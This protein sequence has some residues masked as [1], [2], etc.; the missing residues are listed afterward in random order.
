M[1]KDEVT[2]AK[3]QM[4]REVGNSVLLRDLIIDPVHNTRML[5]EGELQKIADPGIVDGHVNSLLL[6]LQ[7]TELALA[8]FD[9]A[10]RITN[11]PITFGVVK[12]RIDRTGGQSTNPKV[13]GLHD[14]VARRR[15]EISEIG[16]ID[17]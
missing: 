4:H 9:R 1:R 15:I 5:F 12:A 13:M 14:A 16:I 7:Q 2:G 8:R 6:S 11:A 3:L 10:R 17:R